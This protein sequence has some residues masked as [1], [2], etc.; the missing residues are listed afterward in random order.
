M[1]SDILSAS[2]RG[3][4]RPYGVVRLAVPKAGPGFVMLLPVA[5]VVVTPL[6]ENLSSSPTYAPCAWRIRKLRRDRH[7][8]QT[9][10]MAPPGVGGKDGVGGRRLARS[11]SRST[12]AERPAP[13]R[14]CGNLR[15]R[16]GHHQLART[17][18]RIARDDLGR[19]LEQ[20]V[21]WAATLP[22]QPSGH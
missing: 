6:P 7:L 1:G 4:D 13:I 14:F 2:Q 10:A 16:H 18:E 22:S 5:V 11:F 15:I 12:P 21:A 9:A 20:V 17:L 8:E 3:E 19:K